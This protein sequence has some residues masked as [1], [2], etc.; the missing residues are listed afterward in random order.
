MVKS[1]HKLAGIA[2]PCE[3][4]V[5]V[6]CQSDGWANMGPDKPSA[7]HDGPKHCHEAAGP[8][9]STKSVVFRR[10]RHRETDTSSHVSGQATHAILPQLG[11]VMA[12]MVTHALRSDRPA[13]N[14]NSTDLNAVGVVVAAIWVIGLMV[15]I[16]ALATGHLGVASTALLIAFLTPLFGLAWTHL[17][18]TQAAFHEADRF[19]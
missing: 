5:V 18:G 1:L 3:Q 12:T 15:G 19:D 7:S 17:S 2:P 10:T 9:C 16:A 13:E 8:G 4:P 6:D 11:V 14:T